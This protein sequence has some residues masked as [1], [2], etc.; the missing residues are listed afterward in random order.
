MQWLAIVFLS[1]WASLLAMPG[2][3]ASDFEVNPFPTPNGA[4]VAEV[5]GIVEDGDGAV[6][7]ITWGEGVHQIN[8]T[9]WSTYRE[10]DGLPDDWV[11]SISTSPRGGVWVGT[12]EGIARI[13]EGRIEPITQGNFP[14]FTDPDI[15]FVKETSDG[16]LWVSTRNGTILVRDP[17][18]LG[19]DE[20]KAGWRVLAHPDKTGGDTVDQLV[21]VG[22]GEVL[23]SMRTGA[24]IWIR[25]DEWVVDSTL[26][27]ELDFV[28]YS[29]NMNGETI[30]G[31]FASGGA[32]SYRWD[33]AAWIAT[34]SG[35]AVALELA[36]DKEGRLYMATSNGLYEHNEIGWERCDFPKA[37]GVPYLQHI[38]VSQ[39]G[40]I[41][42]GGT[43]G[44]YRATVPPWSQEA[45]EMTVLLPRADDKQP[46]L[47]INSVGTVF[48]YD[49]DG[50]SERFTVASWQDTWYPEDSIWLGDGQVWRNSRREYQWLMVARN[51]LHFISNDQYIV[52]DLEEGHVIRESILPPMRPATGRFF[53]T[54]DESLLWIAE[55]E[56]FRNA[57]DSWQSWPPVP[58]YTPRHTT[59]IYEREP[60]KFWVGL[61]DGI[62]LWADGQVTYYGDADGIDSGD[63]IHGI[64]EATNGELWFGSMGSGIY[65]YDGETFR[66]VTTAEGLYRNSVRNIIQAKDD[67]IW[68][69]YRGTGISSYR[70]DHWV[71]YTFEHGVPNAT[72]MGIGDTAPGAMWIFASDEHVYRYFPDVLSP[73]TRILVGPSTLDSSAVG[74]FS[75]TGRDAWNQTQPSELRYSWRIVPYDGEGHG[76]S[77]WTIFSTEDTVVSNTLSPGGY[78]FQ[79][80]S[81]DAG[82]NIDPTSA[83]LTFVVQ[84][85]F[86]RKPVFYVPVA[87]SL[88]LAALAMAFR[89]RSHRALQASEAALRCSEQELKAHRD[90]LETL[91]AARTDDLEKAQ[92]ELIR[93][94]RLATLGQLTATVSHE[95]RNPLGTIQSSLYMIEKRVRGSDLKLDKTLDRVY[96][97]VRRCD[98]IVEEM[99][100]YARVRTNDPVQVSFDPWLRETLAEIE[101]PEA[102]EMDLALDCG[103]SVAI[104]QES[105]RRV[106]INLVDNAVQA[107]GEI[108]DCEST[109]RVISKRQPDEVVI[110]LEDTGPGIPEDVLEHIFEPLFSTKNFGVGLGTNIVKNI[111]ESHGGTIA[112]ANGAMG[113]ACVTMTLPIAP[114]QTAHADPAYT[115]G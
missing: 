55:N 51:Q 28:L 49:G 9:S 58:G 43:E 115:N 114:D 12:G 20:I 98:H 80:R 13:R 24:A 109:I 107:M 30:T 110:R 81:S 5:N 90:N 7:V 68:I 46:L 41:W 45:T 10:A 103:V 6:W 71:H 16:R 78:Q 84:P 25:G 73:D 79:V 35:P 3:S 19:P 56:V 99:L 61:E 100:D 29:E 57:G 60:G 62:E 95:L 70:N 1:L 92:A 112:Y 65:R 8:G 104:D 97:S 39:D 15:Y 113:G 72:V 105:M 27:A 85:P 83:N 14:L 93:K 53:L 89:F 17:D 69:S 40:A 101:I 94:D 11:R 106:L 59:A 102:V 77:S 34:G 23:L 50:W 63:S 44:L 54:K 2:W 67:T 96:R 91:V 18:G 82:G 86:W 37:L 66:Q 48:H 88:F 4:P 87:F 26:V 52:Y 21:E 74:V 33:G 47:G 111:V 36:S 75:F 38:L 42:M 31:A 76:T 108:E 32:M 64:C 22:P